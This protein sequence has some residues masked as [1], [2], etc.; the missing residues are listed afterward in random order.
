MSEQPPP[1]ARSLG[2]LTD[3][4]VVI[5]GAAG[6][7]GQACALAAARAGARVVLSDLHDDAL[8]QV[9]THVAD[10]GA[11]V[12]TVP[13][14]VTDERQCNDLMGVAHNRFGR[15]DGAV[16][17]AGIARHVPLL[18]M[19][20]AQWENMQ[21]VHLTGAFLCLRAAAT[22][23]AQR[24]GGG[25]VVYVAS[26]AAGG[27]GP[28]HQAHYAAAKAGALGLVRA[29]ARELGPLGIRVNAVS[30]G[31]TMTPMNVGLF[32]ED[33]VRKRGDAAPLR[34]VAEPTDVADTVSFLLADA[35]RFTTGQNLQ[36]DGG[37][38]LP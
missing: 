38:S 24:A 37:A 30:P 33:E 19:T 18:E 20:R 13:V 6:G 3:R 32:T 31:F 36:V 21:A 27:A 12:V 23:M 26:T 5:T 29:A 16:F 11:D 22:L 14:D 8:A 7:I 25:S 34:R 17:A 1:P 9:A 2:G 4:V 10:V 28:L 35:S 15:L